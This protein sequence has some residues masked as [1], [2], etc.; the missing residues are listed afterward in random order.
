[1]IPPVR[2]SSGRRTKFH[3]APGG[4]QKGKFMNEGSGKSLSYLQQFHRI[5]DQVV[6][7][8][9]GLNLRDVMP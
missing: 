6:D 1:M 8:S 3:M 5:V 9:F 7:E 4:R 2:S